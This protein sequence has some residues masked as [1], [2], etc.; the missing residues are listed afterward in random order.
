MANNSLYIQDWIADQ[1]SSVDTLPSPTDRVIGTLAVVGGKD[2]YTID[3]NKMWVKFDPAAFDPSTTSI[4]AFKNATEILTGSDG[5]VATLEGG[6]LI[7]KDAPTGNNFILG[8]HNLDE[9]KD[10]KE[11]SNATTGQV[12]ERQI[13]GTW[14]PKTPTTFDPTTTSISSFENATDILKGT[15]G[16]LVTLESG[17]LVLKDSGATTALEGLSD[18][19]ITSPPDGSSLHYNLSAKMWVNSPPPPQITAKLA[20]LSNGNEIELFRNDQLVIS[21]VFKGVSNTANYLKFQNVF[22]DLVN[23]KIYGM[24]LSNVGDSGNPFK[25]SQEPIGYQI[26]FNPSGNNSFSLAG[27]GFTSNAQ[28]LDFTALAA[29]GSGTTGGIRYDRYHITVTPITLGTNALVYIDHVR[30]SGV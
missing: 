7:L 8:D 20:Q 26:V 21:F 13:D 28:F 25:A 3:T 30:R 9:L 27:L 29:Y 10:T 24:K 16:Q 2:I 12:P 15:D 18:V 23:F 22:P 4:S 5:Q 6:D 14:V 1:A 19:T 11:L 17:N